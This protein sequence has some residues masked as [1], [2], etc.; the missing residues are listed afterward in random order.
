MINPKILHLFNDRI[1]SSTEGL[2]LFTSRARFLRGII[3]LSIAI[4]ALAVT[5]LAGR[6]LGRVTREGLSNS[7]IS[8]LA[9]MI[10]GLP[11][12]AYGVV[13]EGA[14]EVASG[15]HWGIIA[16]N[17]VVAIGVGTA[18]WNYVL[19]TLRAYEASI[20]AC[21]SVIFTAL[22]AIPILGE[23]LEPYEWGGVAL[24]L[25]GLSAV[26]FRRSSARVR[27]DDSLAAEE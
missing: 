5:N 23:R 14:G 25:L 10:G 27:P 3:Y 16:L 15:A 13:T 12:V 7:M 22:F 4:V 18:G 2:G 9:L 11:V 1:Q 8:T 19:R 24:L 26:Q 6:Q 21:S 17:G 20:L